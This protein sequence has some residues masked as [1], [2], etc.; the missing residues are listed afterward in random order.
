MKA[1][2]VNEAI[3]HLPGRSEEE[4]I[5]TAK[6]DGGIN[7]NYNEFIN[8]NFDTLEANIIIDY[9]GWDLR[10][11]AKQDIKYW[12]KGQNDSL[13]NDIEEN[14]LEIGYCIDYKKKMQVEDFGNAAQVFFKIKKFDNES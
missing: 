6:K 5:K 4:I 11:Q 1:K 12:A 13:G 14:L 2:F 3:K 9:D 10:Q 8:I 7:T